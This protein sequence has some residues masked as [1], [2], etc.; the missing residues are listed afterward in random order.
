MKDFSGERKD[1]VKDFSEDK[2]EIMKDLRNKLR[3]KG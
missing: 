2:R 1:I 3:N